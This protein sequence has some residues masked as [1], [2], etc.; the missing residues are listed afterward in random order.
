MKCH[1]Y[2]VSLYTRA[3]LKVDYD[4]PPEPAGEGEETLPVVGKGLKK[5][6]AEGKKPSAPKAATRWEASEHA[7]VTVALLRA[8]GEH[9]VAAEIQEILEDHNLWSV[10][11]A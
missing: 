9:A 8:V 7:T 2:R 4:A 10:P 3:E 5:G 6:K 1:D 11:K